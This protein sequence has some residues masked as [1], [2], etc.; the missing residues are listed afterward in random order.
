[1]NE[2][3]VSQLQYIWQH[4]RTEQPGLSLSDIHLRATAAKSKVRRG[5]IL[6]FVLL[7]TLAALCTLVFVAIPLTAVRVISLAM[8]F[9]AALIAIQVRQGI[10][11]TG[12][13]PRNAALKASLAFYREV[14]LA[15]YRWSSL[16]WRLITPGVLFLWLAWKAIDESSSHMV[17]RTLLPASLVATFFVRRREIAKLRRD[18]ASVDAFEQGAVR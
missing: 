10:Q 9:L 12:M 15:H 14:L 3:Q 4:Q 2:S 17:M 18:L 1:M 8:I 13:L 5:L 11:S 16:R 7:G 6:N